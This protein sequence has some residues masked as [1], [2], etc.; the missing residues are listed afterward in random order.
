VDRH[1]GQRGLTSGGSGGESPFF[2]DDE[3]EA[4]I[5]SNLV[6]LGALEGRHVV[7]AELQGAPDDLEVVQ[8]LERKRRCFVASWQPAFLRWSY[9]R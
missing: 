7:P 1:A 6:Q 4:A 8:R 9:P 5:S 2:G 3:E